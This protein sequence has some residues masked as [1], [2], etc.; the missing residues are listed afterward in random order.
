M[1]NNQFK[2]LFFSFFLICFSNSYSIANEDFNFDVTEVEILENGNKF[3][4]KKGGI[5]T[6]PDGLFIRGDEFEYDKISNILIVRE[7]I[8]FEDEKDNF[9]IFTDKAT[10]IKNKERIYTEGNSR[11]VNDVDNIY[12]EAD[13][14]DYDKLSNILTAKG[15]VKFDDKSEKIQIFSDKV[16]YSKNKEI[17]FTEGNSKAINENGLVISG[18]KLIHNKILNTF[19]AIGNVKIVD[20]L[21]DYIIYAK[22]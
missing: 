21:K 11:A 18:D 7:K 12:L 19:E 14:F 17:I 15:K 8:K 1:K 5:A 10:Y 6:T 2:I 16:T 13:E 22:K 9:K 3:Y 20:P 4:G